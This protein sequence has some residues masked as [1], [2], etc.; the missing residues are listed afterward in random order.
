[1]APDEVIYFDDA[2]SAAF[3][4]SADV[5]SHFGS[6]CRYFVSAKSMT[7]SSLSIGDD[8]VIAVQPADGNL[9]QAAKRLEITRRTLRARLESLGLSLECSATVTNE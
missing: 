3:F 2:K 6:L 1:M 9:M 7:T 4:D 8:D 5:K